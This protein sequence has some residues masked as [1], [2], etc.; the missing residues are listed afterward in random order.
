MTQEDS[1]LPVAGEAHRCLATHG[2]QTCLQV[3]QVLTRIGDK[4]V[5]LIIM[6]LLDRPRRFSELKREIGGISQR[7]LTLTLRHLERD[8]LVERTVTPTIPPRVDY[9]L[10]D[11]GHSLALPARALGEWA[12]RNLET[13]QR[14]RTAYDLV[15]ADGAQ[16]VPSRS[17]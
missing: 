5:I 16:D 3:S 6:L 14:A 9:A 13:I 7:M 2:V 15:N 17:L 11:T 4:W 10:T 8:G 1:F 12:G